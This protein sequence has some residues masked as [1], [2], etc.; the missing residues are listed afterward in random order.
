MLWRD[1]FAATY[2]GSRTILY[3]LFYLLFG[4]CR[5]S[6][7]ILASWATLLC[8]ESRVLPKTLSYFAIKEST[9]PSLILTYQASFKLDDRSHS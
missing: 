5:R 2:N 3:A 6:V 4:A 1:Y 7:Q 9:A 8:I